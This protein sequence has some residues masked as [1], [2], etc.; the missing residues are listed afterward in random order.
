MPW[1]RL[2]VPGYRPVMRV[3]HGPDAAELFDIEMDELHPNAQWLA[4]HFVS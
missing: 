2:P 3:P 1:C 4:G